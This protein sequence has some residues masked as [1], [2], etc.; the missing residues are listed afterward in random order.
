VCDDPAR[1]QRVGRLI[2]GIHYLIVRLFG[3]R[4]AGIS[5]T[6]CPTQGLPKSR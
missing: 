3:A 6:L 2:G 4:P 5:M 1:G